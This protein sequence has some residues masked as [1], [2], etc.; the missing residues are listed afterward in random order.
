MGREF[1][2]STGGNMSQSDLAWLLV[3]VVWL[4]FMG[5]WL[6]TQPWKKK[7]GDDDRDNR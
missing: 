6:Y 3:I 5:Y 7:G 4:C 1:D 2:I